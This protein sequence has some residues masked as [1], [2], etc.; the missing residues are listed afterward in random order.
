MAKTSDAR[1]VGTPSREVPLI[2]SRTCAMVLVPKAMTATSGKY[3][4]ASARVPRRR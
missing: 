3:R 2:F 4:A 1:I